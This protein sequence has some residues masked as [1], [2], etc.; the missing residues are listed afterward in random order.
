MHSS[1][2][3]SLSAILILGTVAGCGSTVREMLYSERGIG[4]ITQSGEFIDGNEPVDL[5]FLL[6]PTNQRALEP[7][8]YVGAAESGD[9]ITASSSQRVAATDVVSE[10]DRAAYFFRD[11]A[12]NQGGTPVKGECS[13]TGRD[14]QSVDN[15]VTMRETTTTVEKFRQDLD[16]KGKPTGGRKNN[17]TESKTT[18]QEIIGGPKVEKLKLCPEQQVM[19]QRRNDIIDALAASSDVKCERYLFALTQLEG[20]LLFGSALAIVGLGSAGALVDGASKI[21]SSAAGGVGGINTVFSESYFQ[22][23]TV[24]AVTVAIETERTEIFTDVAKNKK[25]PE[26][27]FT[28]Q[29]ALRAMAN[30]HNAC[31]LNVGIE[32]VQK[33]VEDK[34]QAVQKA[35]GI[36]GGQPAPAAAPGANGDS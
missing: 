6:D 31:S 35:A 16:D 23:G 19:K 21:L 5:S 25:E 18:K 9:F 15:F 11:A 30:Y 2:T 24:R 17:T 27:V 3:K 4:Q 14:A 20:D 8:G 32:K 28:I 7:L 13:R 22:G 12:N 29:M 10:I 1:I 34:L 36:G 33:T 26:D